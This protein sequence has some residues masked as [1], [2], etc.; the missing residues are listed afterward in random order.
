MV[1]DPFGANDI[2]SSNFKI[3]DP[4]NNLIK[5]VQVTSEVATSGCNKIYEYTWLTDITLGTYDINLT[6]NEG[7]EGTVTATSSITFDVVQAVEYC[8]N[9]IDDDEDGLIDYADP[10]CCE[11]CLTPVVQIYYVPFLENNTL[12][13]FQTVYYPDCPPS[14]PA[15][16]SPITNY[17][18][19][20]PF[21]DSTLIFYDH[22]EDGY[23]TQLS[24][25]S[26]STTEIWGD[27][28]MNNGFPPGYTIDVIL[29][30]DIIILNDDVDPATRQSVIDYDGADKFWWKLSNCRFQGIMGG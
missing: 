21:V 30:T 16:V 3:Y 7:L 25:P 10:D 24:N 6:V 9:G 17:I 8:N 5:D 19:I 20:V 26:Q 28:N 27:G 18:S 13:H 22:W 29:S 12:T 15:P 23:E 14:N 1:S 11:A 4:S 2:T